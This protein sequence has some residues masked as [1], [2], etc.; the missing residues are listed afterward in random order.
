MDDDYDYNDEIGVVDY[1][2]RDQ[3]GSTRSDE[4]EIG[5]YSNNNT[6][7]FLLSNE[8]KFM[9]KLKEDLFSLSQNII[10]EKNDINTIERI[11]K[12]DPLI[13]FKNPLAFGLGYIVIR[14]DKDINKNF[15]E[16]LYNQCS[17][18]KITKSDIIRYARF[19][20]KYMK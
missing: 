12:L 18:K 1:K 5:A 9:K 11:M 10:L 13:R 6:L 4:G 3:I 16:E 17:G 14:D 15:V 7:Q 2:H 19:V 20:S 8:E